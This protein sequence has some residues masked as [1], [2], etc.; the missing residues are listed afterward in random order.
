MG[1]PL[2]H[3]TLATVTSDFPVDRLTAE[4]GS[5]PVG[6]ARLCWFFVRGDSLDTI[7]VS[8]AS[9]FFSCEI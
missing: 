3:T 2:F 1:G 5:L 9:D 7:G 8:A 4:L 6:R